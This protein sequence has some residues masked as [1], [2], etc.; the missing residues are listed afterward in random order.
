M[1]PLYRV[2]ATSIYHINS[3]GTHG[4]QRP[5]KSDS[6]FRPPEQLPKLNVDSSNLFG[7]SNLLLAPA[8]EIGLQECRRLLRGRLEPELDL[9]GLDFEACHSAKPIALAREIRLQEPSAFPVFAFPNGLTGKPTLAEVRT[10]R[11]PFAERC[12]IVLRSMLESFRTC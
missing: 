12:N 10:P 11:Q 6:R 8:Q 3:Y 4:V 5:D 1:S 2:T 7:R 9:R